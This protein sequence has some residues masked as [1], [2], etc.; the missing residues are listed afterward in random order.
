MSTHWATYVDKEGMVTL[1]LEGSP[2]KF[3]P[4][5]ALQLALA[6]SLLSLPSR[7]ANDTRRR[8]DISPDPSSFLAE[9]SATFSPPNHPKGL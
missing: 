7:P 9:P 3:D 6:L 2:Y 5:N 4:S 1:W 8:P